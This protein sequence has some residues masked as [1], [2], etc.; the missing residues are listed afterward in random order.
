MND[1]E[2]QALLAKMRASV[3]EAKHMTRDE[4]RQR[5]ASEKREETRKF[6]ESFSAR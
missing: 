2:R 4:A 1:D 3:E 5:I 6:A